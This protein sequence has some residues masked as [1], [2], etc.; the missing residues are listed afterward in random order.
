MEPPNLIGRCHLLSAN[1][2]LAVQTHADLD[3]VVP[4][5][6]RPLARLRDRAGRERHADRPRCVPSLLGD[7]H[8]LI[9]IAENARCRAGDLDDQDVTGYA[10][11]VLLA[12]GGRG[13]D[14]PGPPLPVL[15]PPVLAV[16]WVRAAGAAAPAVFMTF[17]RAVI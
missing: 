3:L 13:G 10:T 11:P 12:V 14:M 6:E 4:K 17:I 2:R 9:E 5:L 1:T 7:P 8:H 16:T 15:P